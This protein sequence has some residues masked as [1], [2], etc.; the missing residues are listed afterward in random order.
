MD[1]MMAHE[2]DIPRLKLVCCALN[3]V[4][5]LAGYEDD[6]LIKLM[7]MEILFLPGAVL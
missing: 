7:K 3:G 6:D 1:H 5:D 4:I 2:Q